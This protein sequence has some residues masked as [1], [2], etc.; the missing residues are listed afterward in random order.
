M[1]IA[2]MCKDLCTKMHKRIILITCRNIKIAI[3]QMINA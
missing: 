2:V 3:G 1:S